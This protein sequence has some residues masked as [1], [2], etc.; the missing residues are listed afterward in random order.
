M[1]LK[2]MLY[3]PMKKESNEQPRAQKADRELKMLTGLKRDKQ[4]KVYHI[5]LRCWITSFQLLGLSKKRWTRQD[6]LHY[7]WEEVLSF[8]LLVFSLIYSLFALQTSQSK[9]R[10]PYHA[11]CHDANMCRWQRTIINLTTFIF[12]NHFGAISFK[13]NAPH[14]LLWTFSKSNDSEIQDIVL[15]NW[16]Y[17]TLHC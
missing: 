5:S 16:N 6:F 11:Y 4:P 3:S 10:S 2:I 14:S 15:G 17:W 1:V 12:N 7:T 13:T 9:F 8:N